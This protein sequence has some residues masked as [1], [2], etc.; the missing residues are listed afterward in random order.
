MKRE[1]AIALLKEIVSNKAIQPNWISLTEGK[2][3]YEL[4]IKLEMED[5][6]RLKQL[7]EKHN[8]ELTEASGTV[9]IHGKHDE[10]Q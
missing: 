10:S 4:H 6:R 1:Q 7:V 2:L 3:G 9:I 8:L 5:L